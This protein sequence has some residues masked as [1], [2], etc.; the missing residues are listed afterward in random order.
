MKKILTC[1]LVISSMII[2]VSIIVFNYF[3]HTKSN[4]TINSENNEN[5]FLYYTNNERSI[6]L[7]G[8]E[9]EYFYLGKH[10]LREYDNVFEALDTFLQSFKINKTYDNGTT[11]F[12]DNSINVLK[13]NTEDGNKDVYIGSKNMRYEKAFC[14]SNQ[15]DTFI[16]TM[17]IYSILDCI[18]FP[19]KFVTLRQFEVGDVY[20]AKIP[21]YLIKDFE[22]GKYYEFKFRY[23]DKKIE[24]QNSNLSIPNLQSLFKN[25]ELLEII[26]I[27]NS[28]L[29]FKN[30]EINF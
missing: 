11:I 15:F 13:C 14:K 24:K 4:K 1:F 12:S 10:E 5:E 6:Y 28:N 25:A 27:D 16:Q 8:K 20:T 30:D 21:K 22:I 18:E 7:V 26:E 3:N 2:V 19:Y 29:D 23:T 9:N 17:K